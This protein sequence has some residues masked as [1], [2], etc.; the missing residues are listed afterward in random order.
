[1]SEH[2]SIV[3]TAGAGCLGSILAPTLLDVCVSSNFSVVRGD[4]CDETLMR[5]VVAGT[6]RVIRLAAPVGAPICDRD[7]ILRNS[8]YASV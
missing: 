2:V 3:V 8:R 1:M 4:A 7:T 5:K 6:D